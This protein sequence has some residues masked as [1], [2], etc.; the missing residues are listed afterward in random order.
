MKTLPASVT[1]AVAVLAAFALGVRVVRAK[2]AAPPATAT[3]ESAKKQLQRSEIATAL[4]RAA[5]SPEKTLH[6]ALDEVADAIADADIPH[7]LGEACTG[8]PWSHRTYV[9]QC[10]LRR[11]AR[12]DPAAAMDYAATLPAGPRRPAVEAA[13]SEWIQRA[14]SDALAWVERLPTGPFKARCMQAA[15]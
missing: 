1:L 10:L 5:L 3:S 2:E 9:I 4:R 15:I 14:R 6:P 12:T 7:V 11:W 13:L 8:V